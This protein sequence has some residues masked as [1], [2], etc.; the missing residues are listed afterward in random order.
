[1]SAPCTICNGNGHHWTACPDL[2][3]APDAAVVAAKVDA[4][5]GI[6]VEHIEPQDIEHIELA[7]PAPTHNHD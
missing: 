7:G 2:T 1:M 6:V 5:R 3:W 4:A